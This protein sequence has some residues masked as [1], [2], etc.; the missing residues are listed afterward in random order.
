MPAYPR[1]QSGMLDVKMTQ[2]IEQTLYWENDMTAAAEQI[3]TQLTLLSQQERAELAHFL[4][5][6]LEPIENESPEDI[7]AAWLAV[8]QRRSEELRSGKV[9]GIPADQVMAELREQFP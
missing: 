6:S 5:S 7:E 9:V 4:L 2:A 3:K 1:S 8:A